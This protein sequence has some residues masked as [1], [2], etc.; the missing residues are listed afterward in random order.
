MILRNAKTAFENMTTEYTRLLDHF[1]PAKDS[2]GFTER[3]LT[4]RFCKNFETGILERNV[5]SCF[6]WME[7]PL[8]KQKTVHGK[9]VSAPHMDS[10]KRK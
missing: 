1:Y 4:Y 5:V 8:T 2:C 7:F 6:S 3:N 9:R 10:V